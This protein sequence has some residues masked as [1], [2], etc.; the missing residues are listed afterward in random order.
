MSITSC[1]ARSHT[2]A[3]DAI[4]I[5]LATWVA[6][7]WIWQSKNKSALNNRATK[8]L[9]EIGL[10]YLALYLLAWFLQDLQ[11]VVDEFGE[12]GLLNSTVVM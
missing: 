4:A 10:E 5:A 1:S 6:T 7:E 3:R 2:I 12:T 8:W 11:A 9:Y